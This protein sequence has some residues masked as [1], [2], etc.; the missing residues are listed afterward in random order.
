[1]KISG[2]TGVGSTLPQQDMAQKANGTFAEVRA[3]LAVKDKGIEALFGGDLIPQLRKLEHSV[4]TGQKIPPEQLL[5]LQ[6]RTGELGM[7]VELVSKMAESLISTFKRLQ[8]P[9]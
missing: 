4:T 7:R 9:Q 2:I 8:N 5:A 1:M 3:Q 6:I